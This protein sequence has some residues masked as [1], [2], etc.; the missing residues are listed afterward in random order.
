MV[1]EVY[2]IYDIRMTQN[3]IYIYIFHKTIGDIDR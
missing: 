2:F 1:F 3:F